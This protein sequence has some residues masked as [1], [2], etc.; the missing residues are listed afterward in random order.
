MLTLM[1]PNMLESIRI[2][3]NECFN[4]GDNYRSM[5]NL[6]ELMTNN[7]GGCF[8]VVHDNEIVGYIFSRILGKV[9]FIGPLG[10]KPALQGKGLGKNIIKA[11]CDALINAGCVSIGLEVLPELGNNIG[12]YQKSGF[13]PTF[14]TI[15]YRKKVN[16][17]LAEN[18]NVINGKELDAHII[19]SFDRN[20]SNE[21]CGYSLLKDIESATSHENSSIYFYREKDAVTGFLCYSPLISPFVWGAFLRDYSQKAIFDPLFSKIEKMNQGKELRIRINSRYKKAVSMTDNSFEAERS[22]LRMMLNGYEGEYMA[23]DEQSFI[24]RSWVG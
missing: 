1:K 14:S 18:D 5:E 17:E 7:P 11:S 22:I 20:F 23:L 2:L 3:D 12:L 8:V 13:V 15:T 6:A 4:R 21:H 19:T 16:Y 10:I 9:G 24:A